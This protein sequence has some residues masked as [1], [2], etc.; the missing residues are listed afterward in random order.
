MA[1]KKTDKIEQRE[2]PHVHIVNNL[3]CAIHVD[4]ESGRTSLCR[5]LV[6]KKTGWKHHV[7][8]TMQDFEN[9]ILVIME[10]PSGRKAFEIKPRKIKRVG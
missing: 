9:R 5:S 10:T 3:K 6:H 1:K 4:E 7:S 8:V 2:I